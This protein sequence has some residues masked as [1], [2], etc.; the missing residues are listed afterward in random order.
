MSRMV[1]NPSPIPLNAE[2]KQMPSGM[3]QFAERL[4]GKP[5]ILVIAKYVPEN[6]IM[7]NTGIATL[8]MNAEGI[9]R[10]V[11]RPRSMSPRPTAIVE[12]CNDS[13]RNSIVVTA[14]PIVR[15]RRRARAS[16]RRCRRQSG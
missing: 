5:G 7:V 2:P 9:R 10:M 16:S 14:P 4:V 13:A 12:V 15:A 1:L 11:R 6:A 3:N 8:G